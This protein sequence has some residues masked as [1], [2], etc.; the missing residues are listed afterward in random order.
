[1]N[2][3]SLLP[4]ALGAVLLLSGCGQI[5]DTLSDAFTAEHKSTLRGLR[6][7][8]ISSDEAVQPDPMFYVL[9]CLLGLGAASVA[10]LMHLTAI[11][12]KRAEQPY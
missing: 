9:D 6:V 3:A 7:S 12:K 4:A 5:M 8:L 2:R 10:E 11:G 1:M